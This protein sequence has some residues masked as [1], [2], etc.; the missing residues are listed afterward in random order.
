MKYVL[1]L[2]FALV[3][4]FDMPSRCADLDELSRSIVFLKANSTNFATGFFLLTDKQH[5]FLATAEHVARALTTNSVVVIRGS[6]GNGFQIPMLTFM[7][8]TN[9][10]WRFHDTADLALLPIAWTAD[11][12]G[13]LARA[14]Q[15]V[16]ALP[17][18]HLRGTESAPSRAVTLTVLGF[19]L[20]LGTEGKFSAISRETK[21]A[22]GLLTVLRAD[23]HKPAVF[24]ITQ[25]P[26]IG[27]FSGAPVFDTM[28]PTVSSGTLM[29]ESGELQ[30]V[31]IVHGTLSDNTG[32]K[33]GAITPAHE[34]LTLLRSISAP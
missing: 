28:L 3:G 27:G 15:T 17:S 34:L 7:A 29:L 8:G 30:L 20:A 33:L 11:L 2:I 19:P 31:G 18:K 1:V 10:Y 14:G 26:S 4:G 21:P 9:S 22:S 23:T 6:D 25:D 32:G 5:V 12:E 13:E 24:F 16:L